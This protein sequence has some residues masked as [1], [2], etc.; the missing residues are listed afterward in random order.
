M[1]AQDA[2][3][4]KKKLVGKCLIEYKFDGVRVITLVQQ[5]KAVLY[6]RNGF[7]AIFQ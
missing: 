1:L 7:E 2:K 4:H 6:S 3:K 5:G